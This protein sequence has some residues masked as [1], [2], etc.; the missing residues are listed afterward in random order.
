MLGTIVKYN[1]DNNEVFYYVHSV[2][3]TDSNTMLCGLFRLEFSPNRCDIDCSPRIANSNALTI[4]NVVGD[5]YRFLRMIYD[6]G[7]TNHTFSMQDRIAA[8][9]FNDLMSKYGK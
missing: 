3:M 8:R 2:S 9:N 6:M 7:I 5:F 4:H 1:G